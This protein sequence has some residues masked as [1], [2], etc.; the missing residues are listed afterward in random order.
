MRH[1]VSLSILEQHIIGAKKNNSRATQNGPK[2]VPMVLLWW[3]LR[4]FHVAAFPGELRFFDSTAAFNQ[5]KLIS[6]QHY[7]FCVHEQHKIKLS[8]RQQHL[9]TKH[10][11]ASSTV[12]HVSSSSTK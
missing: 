12:L 1:F 5:K 3:H 7:F 2:S 8:I 10:S 9:I 6:K 11:L 4:W